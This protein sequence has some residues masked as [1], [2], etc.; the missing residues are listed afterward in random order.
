MPQP[1]AVYIFGVAIGGRGKGR[2]P[3][4]P[5]RFASF[6]FSYSPNLTFVYINGVAAHRQSAPTIAASMLQ[7]NTKQ[8]MG[9]G[10]AR[11]FLSP[12][13]C[14]GLYVSRVQHIY[15]QYTHTHTR[16]Q[17]HAH[18]KTLTII[19]PPRQQQTP[20]TARTHSHTSGSV[21]YGGRQSSKQPAAAAASQTDR[22]K[23]S[24]AAAAQ[25]FSHSCFVGFGFS[26]ARHTHMAADDGCT[27]AHERAC[28]SMCE[29]VRI[30]PAHCA[31]A[32]ATVEY[33]HY[34]V[35]T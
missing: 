23:P 14:T 22:H 20:H 4:S 19:R 35:N 2:V 12:G 10:E 34:V 3:L 25:R 30:K 7:H 21:E 13:L 5:E 28:V 18:M 17:S 26:T 6:S 16:T 29:C 27:Y 24:R 33:I 8:S 15:T 11:G 31:R 9:R 32:L 1:C